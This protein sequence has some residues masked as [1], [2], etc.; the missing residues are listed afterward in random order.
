MDFFPAAGTFFNAVA[1]FA[2]AAF[3]TVGFFP[4]IVTG[5]VVAAAGF[6]TFFAAL[7]FRGIAF[8]IK[9][10]HCGLPV[11]N[12]G[13]TAL[14]EH[15]LYHLIYVMDDAIARRERKGSLQIW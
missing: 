5:F 7:F 9:L 11:P 2:I 14:R 8:A 6:A 3:F 13:K 4:G 12:A 1:F 15:G 10:H